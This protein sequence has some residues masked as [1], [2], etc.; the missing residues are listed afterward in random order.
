M[1]ASRLGVA[2]AV[3]LS[4]VMLAACGRGDTTTDTDTSAAVTTIGSDA[5]SGTITVWAMG[6]EGEA[7]SDFVSTFE[8]AN[9]DV[10][11]EVTAIPWDS[12]H[13]KIQTAIAAGNGPDVA[14][15][16]TTWMAEF[17]D[18]FAEVPS[19]LDLSDMFTSS[20]GT[21]EVDGTQVGVPW[22]V[23]TR[24]LYYR[25]DLAAEAGWDQAPTTWDDLY[26][27][28]SDMQALDSVDYGLRLYPSGTD[29]YVNSLWAPM[30]AGASLTSDDG[31]EW[32]LDSDA[33][34][35]GFTYTSNYFTSGVADVNASTEP[36]DV[37]A[38]FVSGSTPMFI[39]GPSLAAQI[40]ELGG[41][42]FDSQY[43]TAVLPVEDSGTSFIGGSNLTVFQDSDNPTSAWKLVQWL[44]EPDVQADWY[45]ATT[46]LPASQSAWDEP[47][48][49]ASDKLAAFGEQLNDT[50]AP[51][52]VTTW[53]E[54][55]AAGTTVLEKINRGTV[56]VADGLAE[57]QTQAETIGMG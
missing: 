30:S 3:A 42:G 16:G 17:A 36:G 34:Q 38:D 13:D 39:D 43:T 45:T 14:M 24:V 9:P 23:D 41:D 48:L 37:V 7:L 28:A 46:D 53:S 25:T 56:S 4:V 12:A 10:T 21:G 52:A 33:M 27:M 26:Q 50:W 18:A 47:A 31:S 22:Y 55:A 35:E 11:V 19:D 15:I 49:S 40:D 44:T 54:V 1:R 2:T 6:A 32:T 51:P 8:D 57:L 29:A 20:V 5:A